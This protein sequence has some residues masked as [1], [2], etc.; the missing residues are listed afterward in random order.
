MSLREK[1]LIEQTREALRHAKKAEFQ[2]LKLMEMIQAKRIPDPGFL[3]IG[4]GPA[5]VGAGCS[6]T[7]NVQPQIAGIVCRLAIDVTISADAI[8][9]YI[10][11][12]L[13][14]MRQDLLLASPLRTPKKPSLWRRIFHWLGIINDVL[15]SA[16]EQFRNETEFAFAGAMKGHLGELP[17]ADFGEVYIVDLRIGRKTQVLSTSPI[18]TALFRGSLNENEPA[19]PPV[20]MERYQVGQLLSI[21]IEN[22]GPVAVTVAPVLLALRDD[23]D[24]A[25]S[26]EE[27]ATLEQSVERE[28][29]TNP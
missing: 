20:F 16:S 1:A 4:F 2:T 18:S 25:L 6:I 10:Q 23:L 15:S 14:R 3:P 8:A 19:G 5:V 22:K 27:I 28:L 13:E 24:V 7:M 26:D 29:E 17:R 12:P 9:A 21:V 11:R